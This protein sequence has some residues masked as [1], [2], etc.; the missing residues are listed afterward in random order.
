MFCFANVVEGIEHF[1]KTT[2]VDA[3]V[4]LSPDESKAIKE[5]LTAL[6]P[7]GGWI[8][9][10]AANEAAIAVMQHHAQ[11]QRRAAYVAMGI[12]SSQGWNPGM[13]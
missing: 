13:Q 7:I 9:N 6:P 10:I 4:V 8:S 1:V 12:A 3:H 11:Y 5:E 2:G